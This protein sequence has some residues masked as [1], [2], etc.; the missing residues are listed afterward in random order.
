M[1]LD[2]TETI[3]HVFQYGTQG[4]RPRAGLVQASDGYLYGRTWEGHP[5]IFKMSLDG[6]E[7]ATLHSFL[8]GSAPDF[9]LVEGQDQNL[10]G[11]VAGDP[12]DFLGTIL[13]A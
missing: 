12:F 11:L 9:D 2:G 5:D 8:S 6:T 10:Y 4:Y 13:S 7:F 3:L 1:T